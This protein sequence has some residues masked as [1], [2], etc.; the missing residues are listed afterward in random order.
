[1]LLSSK[2]VLRILVSTK[3]ALTTS[4]PKKQ[5]AGGERYYKITFPVFTEF[6][7]LFENAKFKKL[8]CEIYDLPKMG[9]FPI[10]VE[11]EFRSLWSTNN[12]MKGS[13]IQNRMK[14][15]YP[16]LFEAIGDADLD[17]LFEKN[18]TYRRNSAIQKLA[19]SAGFSVN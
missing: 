17:D 10:F 8:F 15:S 3:F 12:S 19:G 18:R 2:P 16:E 7:K 13:T 11:Q 9:L 5:I 1:M 6:A 14:K 4:V